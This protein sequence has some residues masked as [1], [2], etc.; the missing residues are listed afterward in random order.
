MKAATEAQLN[1]YAQ[2]TKNSID[3]VKSQAFQDNSVAIINYGELGTLIGALKKFWGGD[4]HLIPVSNATGNTVQFNAVTLYKSGALDR[5]EIIENLLKSAKTED[6]MLVLR[7]KPEKGDTVIEYKLKLADTM[8]NDDGTLKEEVIKNVSEKAGAI[9]KEYSLFDKM[10]DVVEKIATQ[11]LIPKEFVTKVTSDPSINPTIKEAIRDLSEITTKEFLLF[12]VGAFVFGFIALLL[13][14]LLLQAILGSATKIATNVTLS[15]NTFIQELSTNTKLLYET[16]LALVDYSL[17][18]YNVKTEETNIIELT[19]KLAYAK[20]TLLVCLIAGAVVVVLGPSY[21]IGAVLGVLGVMLTV[22][23]SVYLVKGTEEQITSLDKLLEMTSITTDNI[24]QVI[25][26]VLGGGL[27]AL[28][29]IVGISYLLRLLFKV[30]KRGIQNLLSKIPKYPRKL[31]T[32]Q[33]KAAFIIG[34]SG[35]TVTNIAKRKL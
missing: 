33:E 34:Y 25:G 15:P 26:Q 30:A 29:I 32:E 2:I 18:N 27:L 20:L 17:D 6:N 7:V 1:Q 3:I 19:D 9:A 28:L 10:I 11:P 31:D 23:G 22:L 4:I 16:I 24:V 12:I 8:L 13:Y 35:K 21:T 14:K 5:R